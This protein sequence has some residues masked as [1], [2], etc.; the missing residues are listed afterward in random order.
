MRV[1]WSIAMKELRSLAT[2]PVAYIFLLSFVGLPA[3][4]YFLY[5]VDLGGRPVSFWTVSSTELDAYFSSFP[6]AFAV[7]I[8]ALSM[9]LWP[10]ELKSGT[11]E[12]LFSYPLRTWQV[13]FGKFLAGTALITIGLAFT[14]ATPWIVSQYGAL[15]WGPVIGAYLGA[16]IMGMAFLAVGLF[17]GALCREQV[18]AFILSAF[19]CGLFVVMGDRLGNL[20]IPDSWQTYTEALS[21]TTRFRYLGRGVVAVKDVAY[22]LTFTGLFLVLNISVLEC[23]KGR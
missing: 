18:S 4:R 3:V 20:F 15:D 22:F 12:L 17:M 1:I 11:V 9:K 16:L 8:P 10:D 21:F 19:V 23:R 2:S 7:L 13:V 5:H 6:F 14:L